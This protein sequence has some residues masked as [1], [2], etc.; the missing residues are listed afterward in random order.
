VEERLGL[1]AILIRPDGIIAWAS[2]SK[3]DCNE[4]KKAAARWL[5]RSGLKR[6]KG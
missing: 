1:K 6:Q 2:D 3:P 4:V 5:V